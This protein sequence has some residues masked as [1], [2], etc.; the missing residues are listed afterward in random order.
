MSIDASIGYNSVI[1]QSTLLTSPSIIQDQSIQVMWGLLKD[2]A[3]LTRL[4]TMMS[5]R[6]KLGGSIGTK[7]PLWGIG[8]YISETGTLGAS[9]NSSSATTIQLTEQKFVEDDIIHLGENNSGTEEWAIVRINSFASGS[10]IYNCTVLDHSTFTFTTSANVTVL[11]SGVPY[12]G[13]ARKFL[14]VHPTMAQNQMQRTRDTVGVGQWEESEKYLADHSLEHQIALG[15]KAVQKKKNKSLYLNYIA[16]SA[17]SGSD[18]GVAGG[19]P[20]FFNPHDATFDDSSGIRNLCVSGAT[21]HNQVDSGTEIDLD[22][23]AEWGEKLTRKGGKEKVL[24][25]SP[26]MFRKFMT[27]LRNEVTIQRPSFMEYNLGFGSAWDMHAL[28]LGFVTF[29][30]NCDRGAQAIPSL[31]IDDDDESTQADRLHWMVAIDPDHTGLINYEVKGKGS[32]SLQ[33]NPVSKT[34]NN[35]IQEVE[36]D[37]TWTLAIDDPETGGYYGITNNS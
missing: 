11:S 19:L 23:L 1:N 5:G 12:D 35:S 3:S 34:R 6:G 26:L 31:V 33:I 8:D 25:M 20:Y 36:M 21:G 14:N 37:S 29:Y 24:N 4:L 18:Y 7:T 27:Q 22:N 17:S 16:T 15:F 32:Q 13:E 10:Y 9:F 2:E 28:D 30:L